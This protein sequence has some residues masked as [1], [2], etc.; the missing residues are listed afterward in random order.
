MSTLPFGLDPVVVPPSG[1]DLRDYQR[2]ALAALDAWFGANETGHPLV[3]VPTGGGKSVILAEFIRQSFAG[4]AQARMVVATH[5][6][7]LID[8]NYRTLLRCWP[9]APAGI[10]S[11]GMGRRDTSH[12][13]TFVGIQSV[14]DRAREFGH[15]DI[16]LVDEAH[17][18]PRSGMGRYRTFVNALLATNPNLRVVGLTATPY[19][20][21]SG[22]LDDGDEDRLFTAVAYECDIVRMIAD[23]WL[24]NVISRAS[25]AAIDTSD[26]ATRAG[27]FVAEQLAQAAMKGTSVRDAVDDVVARA[28]DR[29]SWLFFACGVDH[30]TA[31]HQ[32]LTGR[33]IASALITGTTDQEFRDHAIAKFRAGEIR[34]MVNVNV[35]TTGFDA[36]NVDL[37]ALLRPTKSPGLFVQMVG[38]GLRRAEGK[39]DCLVLDFGGNVMRHG[40]I[41]AIRPRK[42]G[43]ATNETVMAKE[44]P[45]CGRLVAIASRSCPCGYAW[46]EKQA[47][48]LSLDEQSKILRGPHENGGI[49]TWVVQ[50]VRYRVHEKPGKVTSM[51]VDYEC[52]FKRWASEWVCLEHDG[53]ARKKA[54]QWWRSRSAQ[55]VP[56]TVDLALALIESFPLREPDQITVDVRGDYPKL[57][58]MRLASEPGTNEPPDPEERREHAGQSDD[59]PF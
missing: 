4:Y 41:D 9:R 35:L 23:G 6:R 2:D 17:L 26:V 58:G 43:K 37:I 8:Q 10:Y 40:P 38:R 48:D 7:E 12:P 24:S 21:D 18:I 34:A 31:I 14:Y 20:T 46:P 25:K 3:V 56:A 19:R 50:R 44:C 42:P 11:A 16:L 45:S 53:F 59:I 49:E 55:P 5:V 27:E 39:A 33:G 47:P 1:I 30:A 57:L 54:E 22:A 32:G 13:I 52:G 51:R 15:V 29:R 28:G 36:P